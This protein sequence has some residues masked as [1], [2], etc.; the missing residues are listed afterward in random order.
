VL[1]KEY[2]AMEPIIPDQQALRLVVRQDLSDAEKY[3]LAQADTLMRLIKANSIEELNACCLTR[4]SSN[5]YRNIT[6]R[7][8]EPG[9]RCRRSLVTRLGGGAMTVFSVLAV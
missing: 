3:R 5:W 1:S 2:E 6:R 9:D 7:C 8:A 4:A